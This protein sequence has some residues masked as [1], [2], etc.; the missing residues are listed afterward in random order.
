MSFSSLVLDEQNANSI[1][2]QLSLQQKRACLEYLSNNKNL[3]F[4]LNLISNKNF[5]VLEP[6]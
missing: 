6:P 3:N 1:P 4:R 2:F 5:K